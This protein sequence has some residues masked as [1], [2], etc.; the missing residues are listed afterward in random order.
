MFG[1]QIRRLIKMAKKFISR[2]SYGFLILLFTMSSPE[3]SYVVN[4]FDN[5][6]VGN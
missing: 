3:K 5:I 2:S 4:T 6:A 1:F